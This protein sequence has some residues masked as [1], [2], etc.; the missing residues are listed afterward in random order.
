MEFSKNTFYRFMNSVKTNWLRFT[1]ALASE[2]INHE[3]KSLTDEKRVNVFIVDDTL[4]HRTSCKKTELGSRVFDHI[5][6]KFRKGFRLLT[7]GWSDGNTFLL[8]NSC[9]K[10][11]WCRLCIV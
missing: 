3:I 4:F 8:V 11:D 6:M 1:S 5:E 2:I 9:F 10:W 7:L